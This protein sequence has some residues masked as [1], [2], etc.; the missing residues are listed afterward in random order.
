MFCPTEYK[1]GIQGVYSKL[2]YDTSIITTKNGE[3]CLSAML[4]RY[5]ANKGMRW[6]SWRWGQKEEARE[7]ALNDG[8]G[9]ILKRQRLGKEEGHFRE[10]IAEMKNGSEN[11]FRIFEETD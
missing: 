8:V 1:E 2:K 6:N 10:G 7:L 4:Q 9:R 5:G 3:L 11:I